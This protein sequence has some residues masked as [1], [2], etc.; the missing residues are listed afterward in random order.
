MGA[1]EPTLPK[2]RGRRRAGPYRLAAALAAAGVVV[3]ALGVTTRLTEAGIVLGLFLVFL[4]G[5]VLN[6]DR[7][8]GH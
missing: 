5:G 2:H 7:R 4:A 8:S 1:S 6:W 3:A